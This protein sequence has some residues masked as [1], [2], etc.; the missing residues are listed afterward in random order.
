MGNWCLSNGPRALG[1]SYR[2]I[3]SIILACLLVLFTVKS[4]SAIDSKAFDGII[5]FQR[6]GV[7]FNLDL[8]EKGKLEFS[9]GIE[10]DSYRIKISFRHIKLGKSTLVTDFYSQGS[11]VRDEKTSELKCLKGMA[12]TQNTL[13]N[14]KPLKEFRADYELI[15]SRLTINS[16]S[17]ADL[18]LKGY[19]E[20]GPFYDLLLII[21]EM[22]LRDLAGLLGINPDEV[23]LSGIV[24]GEAS[25]RGRQDEASGG[26]N[27]ALSADKY[28]AHRKSGV[29]IET[30]LAAQKG[31]VAGLRF[32]SAKLNMEGLWPILRFVDARVI[33]PGGVAYELQGN[34]NLK[35]LSE[36]NSSEHQVSVCLANN[37]M[38]LQD[39]IIK[40]KA[41]SSGSEYL[42]AEYPIKNH[43]AL[44][45]RIKD[46]EEIFGWE[47]TVKF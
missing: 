39:W 8:E 5:D 6:K 36:F 13:L 1:V 32:D 14:F 17:W 19:I 43:Q 2:A 45:M 9:G 7:S 44:K 38:R 34:F 31:S 16:L 37:A 11:I 22:P 41:G 28:T 24:S 10:G 23:E 35:E 29:K 47:R 4:G 46:Q 40:R 26:V 33:E 18:S 30:K 15:N 12:W 21:K 20:K 42:E 27:P 3:P 25:I